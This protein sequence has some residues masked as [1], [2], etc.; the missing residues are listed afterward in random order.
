MAEDKPPWTEQVDL[1]GRNPE[2]WAQGWVG[3][4]KGASPVIVHLK[5]RHTWPN[6]KWYPLCRE[7]LLG[8]APVIQGLVDQGLI[9]PCQSTCNTPNSPRKETQWGTLDGTGPQG[10]Q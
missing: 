9:R 4:A 2:V 10:S 3:R 7:A 8:I 5:P 6:R 1:P